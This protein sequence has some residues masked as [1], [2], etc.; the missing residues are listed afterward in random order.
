MDEEEVKFSIFRVYTITI[1]SSFEYSRTMLER[2]SPTN[3]LHS[4]IWVRVVWFQM[5]DFTCTVPHS[6]IEMV[7]EVLNDIL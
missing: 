4:V 7:H 5:F 3:I 6:L 1:V 2:W